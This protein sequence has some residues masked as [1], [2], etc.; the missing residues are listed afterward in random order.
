MSYGLLNW[1]DL[2]F[3]LTVARDGTLAKAALR[4][5]VTHST[6]FRRINS[7]ESD[8]GMKLFSRIPEGYRLTERGY[9]FLNLVEHVSDDIDMLYRYIEQS[10]NDVSGRILL[11][12]PASIAH[13]QLPLFISEFR[14][15][16]REVEIN[17]LVS[18]ECLDLQ[19]CEADMAIRI[20]H[21]PPDNLIAHRLT[22]LTWSAYASHSYVERHGAP[23]TLEDLRGHQVLCCTKELL[24]YK[25]YKWLEDNVDDANVVG[26]CNDLTSTSR[27][28]QAGMGLALLPDDMQLPGLVRLFPLPMTTASVGWLLMHPDFRECRKLRVFRDYLIECFTRHAHVAFHTHAKSENGESREERGRELAD[29]LV[30]DATLPP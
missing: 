17:L 2:R 10:N 29:I 15:R 8:I 9:A 22:T 3:F 13:V 18:D 19:R 27:L 30:N 24:R 5:G 20:T 4:L 12:V 28:V 7:L 21:S 1:D 16:Y 14:A 26:R 6:V 11:T 23:A 25:A